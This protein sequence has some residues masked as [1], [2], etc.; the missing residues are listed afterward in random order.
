[1]TT[2]KG[3]IRSYSA[4]VRRIERAQQRNAREAAKR[5]RIQQQQ[6]EIQNAADAVSDYERYVDA[7]KSV[8]K[9]VT[10]AID[11]QQIHEEP[12]SLEPVLSHDHETRA[13]QQLQSYKPSLLDKVFGSTEKKIKRL[14]ALVESARQKDQHA[15]DLSYNEYVQQLE[16]H[17]RL[18]DIASGVLSNDPQAYRNAFEYFGPLDEI[19][20]LGSKAKID[21]APQHLTVGL[22]VNDETVIPNYVLSQTA[23]GKLSKKDMPVSKFNEL[24]QDYICSC[25]LRIARET[26]A[27]LPINLIV[28]N[29]VSNLL[30]SSTGRPQ[31][32]AI[33]SVCI[34]RD[35][36]NNIHFDAIDPSDCMRNFKHNMKFGKTTGFA[37]VQPLEASS[38]MRAN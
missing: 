8:H 22:H 38:L 24:Y 36:L 9:D 23:R 16:D 15:F 12:A 7:L 3:A 26:F 37:A 30:D 31:E 32:Q 20:E 25:V 1:M 5:F 18:H 10:D 11:W 33:L 21:F 27:Y 17:K 34:Y 4:A 6:M 14:E 28:I 2:L 29:A 13:A 35:Q 19:S